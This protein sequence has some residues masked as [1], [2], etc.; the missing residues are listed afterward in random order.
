MKTFIELLSSVMFA[1]TLFSTGVWYGGH[2]A[3]DPILHDQSPYSIEVVRHIFVH[4]VAPGLVAII[5]Q[6]T[7]ILNL[8]AGRP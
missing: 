4:T 6:V 1:W 3:S 5:S 2:V 7:E 8:P